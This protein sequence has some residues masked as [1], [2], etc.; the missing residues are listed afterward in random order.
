MEAARKAAEAHTA[1]R[2]EGTLR[3]FPKFQPVNLWF[4]Y[5]VHRGDESGVLSDIAPNEELKPYQRGMEARK[6]QAK[7][8]HDAKQSQY[9]MAIESFRFSHNDEYPTV[10]E[11][12]EEVKQ[13]AEAMGKTPPS[14]K[15]VRNSLKSL[16]YIVNRNTM[17]ICPEPEKDW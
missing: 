14:E 11:L 5:P 1:W 9:N 8:Q 16:G 7:K 6:R 15:T 4:D 12:Y 13:N 17:K 10:K 2:I 3:E